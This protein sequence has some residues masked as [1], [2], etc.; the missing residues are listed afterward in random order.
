[1]KIAAQCAQIKTV[2]T[3]L[4]TV[5]SLPVAVCCYLLATVPPFEWL[6]LL[7][8]IIG[9]ALYALAELVIPFYANP[10]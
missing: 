10:D 2:S 5:S 9:A 3:A 1:M 6:Y 7:G 4:I 8:L